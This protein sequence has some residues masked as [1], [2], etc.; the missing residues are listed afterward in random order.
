MMEFVLF[1]SFT[2]LTKQALCQKREVDFSGVCQPE[3]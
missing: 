1:T 3:R 2:P